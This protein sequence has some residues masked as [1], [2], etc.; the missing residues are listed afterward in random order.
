MDELLYAGASKSGTST[1]YLAN[2]NQ[3]FTMTPAAYKYN[4][5]ISS[6]DSYIFNIDAS[7]TLGE[8]STWTSGKLFPVITLRGDTIIESGTGLRTSPYVIGE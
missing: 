1:F 5:S 7:G 4:S 8:V 3:Y 6:N 2:G